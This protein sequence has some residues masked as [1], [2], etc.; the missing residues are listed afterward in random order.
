VETLS[1]VVSALP[2]GF[3][4]AV[5]VVL[6]LAPGSPSA[7][8]AILD[9]AGP[10]ACRPA[11][12]GDPLRPGEILAAPPDRHLVIADGRI[13]LTLG[14]RENGHR[15]AID[16]LF[17][18]AAK[19]GQAGVVGV[20]LSGTRDDGTAGLAVIKAYGGLAIVQD[21]REALYG[22]MPASALAHVA[23]DVVV[24]SHQVADAMVR[25]VS[26]DSS[27]P[28]SPGPRSPSGQGVGPADVPPDD[29]VGALRAAVRA[30]EERHSLLERMAA[31]LESRGQQRSARSFRRRATE[32]GEQT[33][34]VRKALDRAGVISPQRIAAEG[35]D[36]SNPEEIAYDQG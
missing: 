22:G 5:C 24:R 4:A 36:E 31:Q 33:M 21:P 32:A 6:H 19:A 17:R 23:V 15:P 13:G 2:A 35:E 11:A 8:A 30:L 9:R 3:P 20:V 29:V 28:A 16:V 25:M 12:D 18:S 27:M 7:L 34:V 14:P 26:G 1:R 10:L